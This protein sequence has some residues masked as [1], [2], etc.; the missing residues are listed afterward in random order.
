MWKSRSVVLLKRT[1]KCTIIN[2][3]HAKN[4][5]VVHY[6]DAENGLQFEG[7][8]TWN[9]KYKRNK[10]WTCKNIFLGLAKKWVSTCSKA[11]NHGE[12]EVIKLS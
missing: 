6:I 11:L 1:A 5:L 10:S 2:C 7:S 4:E 9:K 12:R 3:K 8:N